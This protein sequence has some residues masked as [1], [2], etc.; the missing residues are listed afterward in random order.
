MST[1][2]LVSYA[3]AFMFGLIAF[4]LLFVEDTDRALRQRIARE[5]RRYRG[6][7]Y[8]RARAGRRL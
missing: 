4:G 6:R 1:V 7:C 5:S 3:F 8:Y 2:Y